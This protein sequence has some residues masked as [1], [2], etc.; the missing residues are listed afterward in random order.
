MAAWGVGLSVGLFVRWLVRLL[1]GWLLVGGFFAASDVRMKPGSDPNY[2][3]NFG[4]LPDICYPAALLTEGAYYC[5]VAVYT[6]SFARCDDDTGYLKD[7]LNLMESTVVDNFMGVTTEKWYGPC[8]T[9]QSGSL[10]Q[11]SYKQTT[12][13][14]AWIGQTACNP[15]ICNPGE[16]FGGCMRYNPGTCT[17]CTG[18]LAS[19]Y[20][21]STRG[22][23]AQALC[24]VAG[25][26]FYYTSPCGTTADAVLNPCAKHPGNTEAEVLPASGLAAAQFYCPNGAAVSVPVN[27]QASSDYTTF[28]CNTGYYNSGS[29]CAACQAGS[30]CRGGVA[31]LCPEHYYSSQT[32][33]Y[34]DG[35]SYCKLCTLPEAC[36]PASGCNAD[37]NGRVDTSSCGNVPTV[38]G[39]PYCI[40]GCTQ[41]SQCTSC[42][43]CG[44]WPHTGHNCILGD[45]MAGLSQRSPS[46]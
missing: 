6:N 3:I 5:T 41:N 7:G 4:F 35:G 26:G 31:Q 46:Q 11:T 9:Y 2:S 20:Y 12:Y 33:P 28:I 15:S 30:Y 29:G 17:K 22:T 34:S 24:Q 37:F 40:G 21:F 8:Y 36:I 27:A 14:Y 16:Q 1:F 25:P 23:C 39:P 38:C 32:G 43:L 18:P 45:E 13:N 19:G 42:G 44:S 10:V